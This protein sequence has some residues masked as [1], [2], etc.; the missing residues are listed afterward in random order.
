MMVIAAKAPAVVKR[1]H[2]VDP[3]SEKIIPHRRDRRT[4]GD[5]GQNRISG[6]NGHIQLA[7]PTPVVGAMRQELQLLGCEPI[8]LR[9]LL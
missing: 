3:H 6:S 7:Q 9:V 1:P 4:L 8:S 5:V 2:H